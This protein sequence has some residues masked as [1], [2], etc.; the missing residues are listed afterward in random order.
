MLRVL[1]PTE[2]R[3]KWDPKSSRGIFVGYEELSKAYHVFDVDLGRVIISR[4]VVFDE[5]SIGI[6]GKKF[7]KNDD[8][9]NIEMENFVK[10]IYF[11]NGIGRLVPMSD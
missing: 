1:T 2:I 9:V 10:V 6:N 4:D 5:S 7:T 8:N 3:R 11:T